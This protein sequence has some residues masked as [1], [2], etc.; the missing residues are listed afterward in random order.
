MID[1]GTLY[2]FCSNWDI[3]LEASAE[4]IQ[5]NHMLALAEELSSYVTPNKACPA[6]YQTARRT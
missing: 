4:V 3:L 1:D 6:R 2:E 5:N